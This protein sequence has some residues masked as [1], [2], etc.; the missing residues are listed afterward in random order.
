MAVVVPAFNEAHRLDVEAFRS[1]VAHH[2]SIRIVFVDDG[3]TDETPAVLDA[4]AAASDGRIER[5]T[6]ERNSGKAEAVRRG[7]MH[8]AE[9][10]AAVIGYLDADLSAPLSSVP[11][12]LDALDQHPDAWVILGSRVRLLG[13]VVERS[14]LRHYLGRVF[15]TAASL[16][17]QLPVY[18]TQCGCKLFRNVPAV[19][20]AL[21]EAFLSRWIFDVELLARIALAEGPTVA[22][23]FREVPLEE[24]RSHGESH[25]TVQDWFRAPWELLAIRARYRREP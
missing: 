7:L 14:A 13:R 3:S 10:G 22:T 17:L 9:S 6:L 23:R 21:S 4:L 2:P 16:T 20:A 1:F 19:R 25:L 11:L 12:L 24:W 18:D 5:F 15:A 8:A